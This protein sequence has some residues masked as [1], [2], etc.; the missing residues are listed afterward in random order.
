M[1][2][3]FNNNNATFTGM[4]ARPLRGLFM[5]SNLDGIATEIKNLTPQ[6]GLKVYS[7]DNN[8]NVV[9]EGFRENINKILTW[10][11]DLFSFTKNKLF[12]DTEYTPAQTE[13][14]KIGIK[15][16]EFFGIKYEPQ[17]HHLQGGNYILNE[18]GKTRDIFVGRYDTQELSASA[19]ARSFD[20]DNVFEIPQAAAHIDAFMFVDDRKVYICDDNLMLNGIKKGIKNIET[21]LYT[22]PKS[23]TKTLI[24]LYVKLLKISD[25]FECISKLSPYEK[26]EPTINAIEKA[27]YEAIRIPARLYRFIKSRHHLQHIYGTNFANAILHKNPNGET[28]LLTNESSNDVALGIDKKMESMI[29]F[30]FK[31]I[32][33]DALSPHIKK[34]NIHFIKGNNNSVGKLL[35]NLGGIHCSSAEI[36]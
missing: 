16:A 22:D 21:L 2:I 18:T 1:K 11:Q 35:S 8:I 9:T 29:N 33:L 24:E 32:F 27:G 13:A 14:K 10:S 12:I 7:L 34:E 3:N 4:G 15:L 28:V 6:T 5:T 17:T 26:T 31:K 23:R 25:D 30:S 20:A 36:P 19:I